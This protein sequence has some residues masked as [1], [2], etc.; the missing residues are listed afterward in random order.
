MSRHDKQFATTLDLRLKNLLC[1]DLPPRNVGEG[2]TAYVMR[3][4]DEAK[5]RRERSKFRI[6]PNPPTNP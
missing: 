3:C 5:A 4:A 6:D 1:G 2:H